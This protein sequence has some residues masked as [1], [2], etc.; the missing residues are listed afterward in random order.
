[1]ISPSILHPK[2]KFRLVR[3]VLQDQQV[4]EPEPVTEEIAVEEPD[5]E[6]VQSRKWK[7]HLHRRKS[8]KRIL[9]A[10]G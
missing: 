2:R 3:L 8:T 10:M 6:A 5:L 1:M 7:R 9:R 4:E